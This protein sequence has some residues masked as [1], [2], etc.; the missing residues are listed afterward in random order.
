MSKKPKNRAKRSNAVS[1][2]AAVYAF[3][4]GLSNSEFLDMLFSLPPSR[5]PGFLAV[6]RSY[7]E[8]SWRR[9]PE[10]AGKKDG[11]PEIGEVEARCDREFLK[12]FGIAFLGDSTSVDRRGH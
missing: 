10:A 2:D 8:E 9:D 12:D 4:E 3:L 1:R 11:S 5:R 6:Y 7:A